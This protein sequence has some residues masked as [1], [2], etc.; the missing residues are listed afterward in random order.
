[1]VHTSDGTMLH[2]L[3][4]FSWGTSLVA[5]E[6]ILWG[7]IS[8]YSWG[9]STT[10]STTSSRHV[11]KKQSYN[12][13]MSRI[14]QPLTCSPSLV[15]QPAPQIST[16][17]LSHLVSPT[18]WPELIFTRLVS[19][20]VS[21]STLHTLSPPPSHVLIRGLPHLLTVCWLVSGTND[22]WQLFSKFSLHT[23]SV[24]LINCLMLLM[25][26]AQCW[27]GSE[28]RSWH[29]TSPADHADTPAPGQSPLSSL[30]PPWSHTADLTLS[31]CLL[32]WYCSGPPCL[33]WRTQEETLVRC[34]CW[35]TLSHLSYSSSA[36]LW[37]SPSS[38]YQTTSACWTEDLVWRE[39]LS[40]SC[41]HQVVDSVVW[42]GFILW[43]YILRIGKLTW[44]ED[45]VCRLEER[46]ECW[47]H[48][49]HCFLTT[50]SAAG[51]VSGLEEWEKR[52]SPPWHYSSAVS[53]EDSV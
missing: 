1:M 52:G 17:N 16:G 41:Q 32:T 45:L 12:W 28:W 49:W 30:C 35:G 36:W 37:S 15:T 50:V 14:F 40:E 22:I 4:G 29:D 9:T 48:H 24:V 21:Y 19:H 27:V 51:S 43:N 31:S 46:G 5:W 33:V 11:W 26:P 23:Y 3:L 38:E 10:V 8:Q 7:M 44:E 6:Q 47:S 25:W 39:E 20:A 18:Y 42:M 2:S 13:R 34:W 53:T